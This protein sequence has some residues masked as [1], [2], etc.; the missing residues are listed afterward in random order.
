[1]SHTICGRARRLRHRFGRP[2]I[3]HASI[4][5]LGVVVA[6]VTSEYDLSYSRVSAGE[7][8][9]AASVPADRESA[10]GAPIAKET[11]SLSA[12]EALKAV[13]K[14]FLSARRISENV[15][16]F[17]TIPGHYR[18]PYHD[19]M[20]LAGDE[21]YLFPDNTYVYLHWADVMPIEICDRGTWEY[22]D[23]F[24][25]LKT[26]ET[27]KHYLRLLDHI[28]LPVTVPTA[29][30]V[31][32]AGEKNGKSSERSSARAQNTTKSV[33]E[34]I[35]DFLLLGV[36]FTLLKHKKLLRTTAYLKIES[37]SFEEGK[38][39]KDALLTR[40]VSK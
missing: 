38:T 32:N 14:E 7:R 28:Y 19:P 39:K 15:N 36:D 31:K 5:W 26:D 23:G 9:K 4:R 3:R 8:Q 40:Q 29:Q 12:Q 16:V 22:R 6:L 2:T 1:M 18:S 30:R 37:I 20:P 11:M 24:V 21:L 34:T 17:D 25:V 10:G 35:E 13:N 33:A 27:V